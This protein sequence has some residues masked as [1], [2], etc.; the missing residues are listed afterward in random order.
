MVLDGIPLVRDARRLPD[1]RVETVARAVL[2]R[3]KKIDPDA[4]DAAAEITRLWRE[5][6]EAL[7]LYRLNA[8]DA[9]VKGALEFGPDARA[10]AA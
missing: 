8:L 5:E 6:P 4:P 9:G 3:G 2:G 10:Q 1:Y 7:A